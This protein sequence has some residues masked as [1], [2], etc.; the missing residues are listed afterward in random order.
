M[1][2]VKGWGRLL[3]APGARWA[4]GIG[5]FLLLL[6]LFA[7]SGIFT[8][9]TAA[10]GKPA[11]SV[12]LFFCLILAYILPVF[13]FISERSVQ[14]LAALR[15]WLTASPATVQGWQER[16]AR[17]PRGWRLRVAAIGCGIGVLHHLLLYGALLIQP[18]T[19]V[20]P[21]QATFTLAMLLVWT[22]MMLALSALTEN[23]V[24]FARAAR[25]VQVEPLHSKRLR[26]FAD[27]AIY[28][29]LVVIGALA[30]F[31]LQLFDDSAS[32][33]TFLPG[34]IATTLPLLFIAALPLWPIHSRMAAA[35]R[36]ALEAV[37]TQIS[38]LPA[39]DPA[40]PQTLARLAPLL[41]YRRELLAAQEWPFDL[42]SLGRLLL[43]LVIPPLTWL[44]AALIEQALEAAL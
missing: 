33:L 44:G 40:Q 22:V 23:A 35:K 31:P 14:A 34:I 27:A 5:V 13:H 24:I 4:L 30:F 3:A 21:A 43:Y 1:G 37:E 11:Q 18:F 39:P 36:A 25:N 2:G 7:W 41:T 9:R 16:L 10:D 38:A 6:G 26:P 19:S 32:P 17:K 8:G 28:P 15:P 20:A 29:T 12:S 42:G